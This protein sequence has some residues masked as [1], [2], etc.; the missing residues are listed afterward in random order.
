MDL[1]RSEGS[2]RMLTDRVS[3]DVLH[4]LQDRFADL[5]RVTVCLCRIDGELITSPTWG[6]PF[7]AL[8]GTSPRGRE[9]FARAV[10]TCVKGVLARVPL[11]CHEGMTLHGSPILSE[12][13]RLGVIVVG[14]RSPIPPPLEKVR[15]I[16]LAYDC[17][18]DQLL[19]GVDQIDPYNGGAPD[20]IHR[21]AEVL[22]D[23]I[24]SLYVQAEA[25]DRQLTDLR[26]VHEL[27]HMLAGT[28]DLQEILDTTARRVVET[29]AVK[30]SIIR[31]LK[32][33]TGELVTRAVCHLSN[34]YL[35]K[36][37]VMLRENAVDLAAFSGEAV[38]IENMATDPRTR[39]PD[40]ARR[41][42]IVSGLCVPMTFRGQTVGVL[43]AYTGETRVFAESET[44]MLRSI[45]SQAAAAIINGRLHEEN[46]ES[47]R[48]QRQV[49]VA[50]QIQRRMMPESPPRV[51]G[52]AFGCVYD[53]SLSVGGDFY[54]FIEAP[55]AGVGV[56]IADVV[57]KGIPAALMMASVRSALRAHA[58]LTPEIESIMVEVNRHMCR[59]TLVSEFATMFYG[60]FSRD[61]RSFSYSNAGHPHPLWLHGT[62]IRMLEAGGMVVG[63]DPSATFDCETI[64]VELGD[65]IVMV[66]DGVTEAMDFEGRL[67]GQD[68]L[69][70]SVKKHRDLGAHPMAQQLLWDVRRFVGLA[71]QSDDI[72][73][74]V[75]KILG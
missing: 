44:A 63:V 2:V 18:V 73:I 27:S 13:R 37:P 29:M 67:Y 53:P 24:A 57:G 47:E 7:S 50:G 16:A 20:A 5:G 22:A 10:R 34:A 19:A 66:T 1:P 15:E 23:T 8:I 43:L 75:T 28:V 26:A 17:D 71:D 74:V 55:N 36:G 35:K 14:T 64:D 62:Q 11:L 59:D 65:A 58:T 42:G 21:F 60:V 41:A 25:I 31:L 3:L 70:K 52:L 61:G 32:E 38:Y 72:T 4:K 30:A 51:K 46:V 54:D 56:C 6:S 69:L 39:Y 40:E 48:F 49:T 45:A 12:G 9:E 68:R 33:D